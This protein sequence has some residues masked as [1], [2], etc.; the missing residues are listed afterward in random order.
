MRR[1]PRNGTNVITFS[2]GHSGEFIDFTDAVLNHFHS[3]RQ[4]KW[5]QAEACGLLFART[6]GK[7]IIID[8]ATGPYRR[9]WRRRYACEIPADEAQREID[10][11]HVHGLHYVGEWHSHPEPAPTPSSRDQQTMQSRV[12]KSNHRMGGF[13]FALIGQA[14][15]SR[16]LTVLV[17]DGVHAITL[18][19]TDEFSQPTHPPAARTY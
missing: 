16:G 13:I 7:H 19:H 2:V 17:H 8:D 14:E 6:Q 10:E 15:F 11:R 12:L 4:L 18:S 5:W 9:G 3:H 1:L